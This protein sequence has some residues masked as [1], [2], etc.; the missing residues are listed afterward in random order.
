[1]LDTCPLTPPSPPKSGERERVRGGF[2]LP[3]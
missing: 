2:R 1:M 3:A